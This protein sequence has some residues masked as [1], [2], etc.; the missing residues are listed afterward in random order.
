MQFADSFDNLLAAVSRH[1]GGPALAWDA[2]G[3]CVL[4]LDGYRF[5][6]IGDRRQWRLV[7]MLDLG[8]VAAEAEPLLR[9]A[10]SYN[11]HS[12]E[13]PA[14]QFGIDAASGRLY[15]FDV[16]AADRPF[17][18][19]EGFLDRFFDCFDRSVGKTGPEAPVAADAP[20]IAF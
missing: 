6:L 8:V 16:F 11:F 14:P 17:D 3:C 10:L 15:L 1:L 12:V 2:N 4:E 18:Q 5:D 19:F 7:A 20:Q 13:S 9:Q